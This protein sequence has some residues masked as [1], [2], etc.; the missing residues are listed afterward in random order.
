MGEGDA[1]IQDLSMYAGSHSERLVIPQAEKAQNVVFSAVAVKSAYS[2]RVL[3]LSGGPF[4]A[5][6]AGKATHIDFLGVLHAGVG[7]RVQRFVWEG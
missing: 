6:A 1:Y 7:N 4:V 2:C 3:P 5:R